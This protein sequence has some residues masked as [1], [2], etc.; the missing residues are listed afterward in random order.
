MKTITLIAALT[1]ANVAN[2]EDMPIGRAATIYAYHI[3]C[4]N[5]ELVVQPEIL[6]AAKAIM[7]ENLERFIWWVMSATEYAVRV[8][9]NVEVCTSL[10]IGVQRYLQPRFFEPLPNFKPPRKQSE[11][12]EENMCCDY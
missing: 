10:M 12:L 9:P 6:A 4:V 5:R 7:Q 3:R 1:F 8:S 2:A 11:E